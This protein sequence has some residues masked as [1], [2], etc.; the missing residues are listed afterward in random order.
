MTTGAGLEGDGTVGLGVPVTPTDA[1][2]D[3]SV[4]TVASAGDPPPAEQ[5]PVALVVDSTAS[6]PVELAEESGVIVVPL[7][8][9]VD[10]E[11]FVEGVDITAQEVTDALRRR[12]PVTTSRPSPDAFARAYATAAE[13]GAGSIVSVHP[14]AELSG[15][16]GSARLAAGRA[17]LPV[18]L[19]D[20]RAVG[21]AV[22][23]AAARAARAGRHGGNAHDVV[24]VVRRECGASSTIF[25]VDSLDHLRRGGRIGAGAAFLSARLSIKPVL[26]L[27]KGAIVPVEKVR[28]ATKA[29][30]RIEDIVTERVAAVPAWASGTEIVVEHVDAADRAESLARRLEERLPQV[31]S[32]SVVDLAAVV[33]VHGGPGTI[34]VAVCPHGPGHGAPRA[35]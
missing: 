30:A 9:V 15:T 7:H 21:M 35:H 14:S 18:H 24:D 22:G 23:L 25:Y 11:Q 8:V 2:D 33:A 29:L 34:G 16:I 28:T 3:P 27:R 17:E 12:A 20:S 32:V 10:D 13:R 6:L 4:E 1:S 5:K 31:G 19:V 26:D